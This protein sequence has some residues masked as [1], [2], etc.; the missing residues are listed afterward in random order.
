M[1][2]QQA[3]RSSAIKIMVIALTCATLVGVSGAAAAHAAEPVVLAGLS[4]LH[5]N[6][7]AS[8]DGSRFL[9]SLEGRSGQYLYDVATQR[10]RRVNT[11]ADLTLDGRHLIYGKCPSPTSC[12]LIRE[13][14]ATHR[15]ETVP[16]YSEA[17]R[18]DKASRTGRY[19]F[20]CR[21]RTA[22]AHRS[23]AASSISRRAASCR[24]SATAGTM[25]SGQRR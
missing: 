18:Q 1:A 17:S 20:A 8:E 6:S 15:T 25:S 24:C 5:G 14:L 10:R 22:Q 11:Y 21:A 7:A 2:L 3:A 23:T 19:V 16:G 13:D 4:H 12:S 9:F